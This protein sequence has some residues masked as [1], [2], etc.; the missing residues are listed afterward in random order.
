MFPCQLKETIT[1]FFKEIRR[2]ILIKLDK[3]SYHIRT[4][5]FFGRC[6]FIK[7][8]SRFNFIQNVNSVSFKLKFCNKIASHKVQKDGILH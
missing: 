2:S 5:R 6:Q 7:L 3:L 4:K 1:F 8:T